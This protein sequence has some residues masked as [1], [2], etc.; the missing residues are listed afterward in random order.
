MQGAYDLWQAQKQ[1]SAKVKSIKP[2]VR[3]T[4]KTEDHAHANGEKRSR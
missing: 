1:A 2:A 3:R 4:E